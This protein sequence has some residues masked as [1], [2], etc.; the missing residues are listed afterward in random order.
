MNINIF[1][2]ELLDPENIVGRKP[3]NEKSRS[4]RK[5]RFMFWWLTVTVL[6]LGTGN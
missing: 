4:C 2:F 5:I 6:K 1:D 3:K